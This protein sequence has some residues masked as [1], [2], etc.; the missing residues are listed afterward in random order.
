MTDKLDDKLFLHMKLEILDEIEETLKRTVCAK[1]DVADERRRWAFQYLVDNGYVTR[2][3]Y[4]QEDVG[5]YE[6]A[7]RE[8]WDV[9]SAI[10]PE[11]EKYRLELRDQLRRDTDAKRT[12]G[13]AIAT[14]AATVVGIA[15]MIA[16]H[17][18]SR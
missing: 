2:S 12:L 17:F 3:T 1:V 16:L 4:L 9:C 6:P 13:W 7:T 8:L 18:L 5:H 10:T 14:F 15:V 11:G